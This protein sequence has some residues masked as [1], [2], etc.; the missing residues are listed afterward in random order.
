MP[1]K[2][3]LLYPVYQREQPGNSYAG[4]MACCR[5]GHGAAG[6]QRPGSSHGSTSTPRVQA[7]NAVQPAAASKSLATGRWSLRDTACASKLCHLDCGLSEVRSATRVINKSSCR[8]VTRLPNAFL[9][10]SLIAESQ[11]AKYCSG[12]EGIM[13]RLLR[14]CR[15]KLAR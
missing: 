1:G 12:E 8:L 13:S 4:G 3:R 7:R 14:L 11:P 10:P 6:N 15:R 9:E 5:S 2:S